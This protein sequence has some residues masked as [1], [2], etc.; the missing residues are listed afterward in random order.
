MSQGLDFQV[1]GIPGIPQARILVLDG[2][3]DSGSVEKMM[4]SVTHLLDEGVVS[5]VVDCEHLR[6]VNSTGLG[7]LLHFTRALREQGGHFCLAR[8]TMP[9]Y[10]IMEIIGANALLEIHDSL[11]DAVAVLA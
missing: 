5:L 11:E 3:L 7:I 10:E 8:V 1:Q 4:K 9:V 2:E 6:Y